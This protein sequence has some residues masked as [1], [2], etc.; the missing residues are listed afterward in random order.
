MVPSYLDISPGGWQQTLAFFRQ[1]VSPCQ[2]CPRRCGARRLEG[3]S[4]VCQAGGALKIA[5]HNLHFGEEPPISAR[6]GSGTVFFSGCTL[7]CLFCQNYPISHLFNGENY[8]VE[9]LA[10]IFLQLQKQGAHNINLVSPT[11]YLYHIVEALHL[12]AGRGLRLPFVFNTSGYERSEVVARLRA[13][14]DVYLPDLKYSASEAGHKLALTLSGA[15]DYFEHAVAAIAEMFGQTGELLLDK[16]GAAVRG[17]IIRHLIL[18]GQVQNSLEVLQTMAES[19]FRKAYLS[20]MSQYFPAYRAAE[21]A[22][23]DR[24]LRPAEYRQVRD[25]ALKLGIEKGWFQEI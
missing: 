14:V 8:S 13:V 5:S 23:L 1:Q 16:E 6:R 2:L 3:G 12:A 15:K 18:P 10:A 7:K 21:C 11:P 25:F 22:G 17:T 19:S 20:L 24:R 4:G 9:Q